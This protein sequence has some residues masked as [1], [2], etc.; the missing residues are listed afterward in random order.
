MTPAQKRLKELRERQSRERQRMAELGMAESLTD[1]TRSELDTIEKSTPDLERQLR[2]ATVAVEQEE[3]EQK[4]ETRDAEPDAEMRERRELR[5]KARLTNYLLA[6]M[7]GQLPTGAEAELQAAAGVAQI[8]I[9]LYDVPAERRA[10]VTTPAPAND[11]GVN[12]QPVFPLIYARSVLPRCGVAM[13]RTGSGAYA[14]ATIT[15]GLTAAAQAKGAAQE[16]TAA[17]LTAKSTTPHRVSARLSISIEDV[18]TIGTDNFESQLRGALQLA[19]S[20]RLDHLGLTGDGQNNNPQGLLSQL[21]DPADETTVVDFDGFVALAADGI[22]GGPWAETLAGVRLL[23]NAETMRK[24]ETTFQAT[25]TYKGEMSAG[26]YLRDKTGG[27]FASARMPK[28]A[29]TIAQVLRVRMATMGLDGV[30]AGMLASCPV[31][32]EVGIDDIFSDSASGVRH[33]TLHSLVGDVLILQADAFQRV[34][35]KV[36]A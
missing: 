30:N 34:D 17:A 10:D 6:A 28:T 20:D 13:P 9:E 15:T 27:F 3:A 33:F 2:A 18:A 29:T 4:T 23:V 5:S 19:L 8:P 36:S 21:A 16:A 24:A 14:T 35:L 31:W 22:D 1:E 7:R 32:A 26:A 11:T 12:L 25:D